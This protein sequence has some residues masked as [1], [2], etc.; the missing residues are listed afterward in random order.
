[1]TH[2]QRIHE[3]CDI[4]ERRLKSRFPAA[5]VDFAMLDDIRQSADALSRPRVVAA[6][7]AS[8]SI[9]CDD[10]GAT[11]LCFTSDK[12]PP[13]FECPRCSAKATNG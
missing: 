2:G 9:V 13:R 8:G 7:D 6:I 4:L 12:G 10:C 1:M 11:M 5:P 3:C